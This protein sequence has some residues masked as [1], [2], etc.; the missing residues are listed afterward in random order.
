MTRRGS[1]SACLLQFTV[2]IRQMEPLT[3]HWCSAYSDVQSCLS[4]VDDCERSLTSA[5][6]VLLRQVCTFLCQTARISGGS[7]E[8]C[9]ETE[10]KRQIVFV[11]LPLK[12]LTPEALLASPK[13]TKYRLAAGLRSDPL[14]ELTAL[15]QTP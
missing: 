13:C 4:T 9:L 5:V 12:L 6:H 15:P 1:S 14:R 7:Y 10:Y 8:C 11:N 3:F 2:S